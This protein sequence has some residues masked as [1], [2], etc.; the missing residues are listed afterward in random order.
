MRGFWGLSVYP[1]EMASSH[2]NG[3]PEPEVLA[4]YADRGLSLAERA[5]VD[6]HLASCPQCIA[7]LAGVARTVEELSALRPDVTV[8]AEATPLVT[9]RSLAGVLTA[10]AAVIA[11]VASPAIVRPLL[12]RDSGLVSLVD[13]V[14]EQRSVL[15]RLTGGLPHAPLGAPSAGGQDGQAA[16]TDRVQL[17]AGRIRESF[18]EYQTPSALH[19]QGVAQLLSGRYDDAAQSL[20]AASREQPANA[21]YMNDVATVQIERARRGLRPDDLPR[22]LAAA[23]RALRLDPSLKEAWFNR[24]LA[25]GALSLTAE[26][27]SAW[28]E[29]LKRDNASPW[30]GEARSRLAELTK[31][32]R[33]DAWAAI[34]GRLQSGVDA[35]TAD[36]AVRTQTTEARYVTERLFAAWANAVLAGTSGAA[37]L[38]RVRVMSTAMARVTGDALYADQV[39]AID[40][41]GSGAQQLAQAHH[42]Y[43]AAAALFGDDRF[44]ASS[45]GFKSSRA[46]FGDSPFAL[47]AAL[48]EAS[49]AYALGRNAEAEPALTSTLAAARARNYGYISG[50][51]NWFLGLIAMGQSR[52]ADGQSR[53]E[54]GL[55]AFTRLGDAE[56][57]ASMHNLLA[58]R[59]R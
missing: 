48:Q 4:A 44:V 36:E 22:A 25:A 21:R 41:A 6:A 43:A 47:L 57:A 49:A 26:A 35:A 42:E 12:N 2:L 28:A 17:T 55:D 29:Y 23:D 39:S 13:S 51:A 3:C 34:E 37:E 10:A 45:S 50:R 31:P 53:Y 15:G 7:M 38:E 16:G 8:I 20:L 1:S 56:Q 11:I 54:E 58:A 33:A 18:G 59:R 5:R 19:A 9:W 27:K 24:A 30:A 46:R 40:R 52:F 32:T 14:G